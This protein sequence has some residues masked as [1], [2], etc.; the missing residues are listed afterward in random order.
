MFWRRFPTIGSQVRD[1][2]NDR[3]NL[4]FVKCPF[5]WVDVIEGHTTPNLDLLTF[6]PHELR[7]SGNGGGSISSDTISEEELL[8]P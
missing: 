4:R 3:P 5:R 8:V 7:S 2:G 6:S 1:K